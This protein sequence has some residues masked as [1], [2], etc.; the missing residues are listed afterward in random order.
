MITKKDILFTCSYLPE[1]III[2]AGLRPV[3]VISDAR[4]SDADTAIHPTTCPY[5]RAVFA[6]AARGDHAARRRPGDRQL[7]RRDAAA[8]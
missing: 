1:E 6:A 8:L 2:A 4:P 3:R 5:I 7:V